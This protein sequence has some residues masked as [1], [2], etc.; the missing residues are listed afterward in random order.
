[1]D[2]ATLLFNL[3]NSK[4]GKKK[5]ERNC[6]RGRRKKYYSSAQKTIKSPFKTS[7]FICISNKM[8][9]TNLEIKTSVGSLVS[10]LL[11]VN[12]YVLCHCN[13]IRSQVIGLL[14]TSE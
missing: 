7:N 13:P 4:G 1:M 14:S 11:F 8:M 12:T 6:C 5:K 9:S 3:G 10:L 2:I